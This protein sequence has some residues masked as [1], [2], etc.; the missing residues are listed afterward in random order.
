MNPEY[1][2]LFKLLLIGD[3]GV[4]KS[5]LLL[6]FADDSYIDSYVSTI[7]VILKSAQLNRMGRPLSSKSGIQLG[8]NDSGQSPVATTVGHMESLLSMM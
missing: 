7:G 8:K 2:Y 1:D 3:S 4:G 5:C 6:R